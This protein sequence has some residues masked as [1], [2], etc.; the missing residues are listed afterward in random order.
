MGLV[1]LEKCVNS[2]EVL[3]EAEKG[4]R[5]S[6]LE[7]RESQKLA[8]EL[9]EEYVRAEVGLETIRKNMEE[10]AVSLEDNTGLNPKNFEIKIQKEII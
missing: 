5:N 3:I 9:K 7:E 8:Q 2:T 4:L 1:L 6:L 10:V